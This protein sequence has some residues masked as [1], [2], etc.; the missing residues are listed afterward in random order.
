MDGMARL[1]NAQ[2]AYFVPG[3]T[4]RTEEAREQHK[5]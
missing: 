2:G 1:P 5:R 4:E 3:K